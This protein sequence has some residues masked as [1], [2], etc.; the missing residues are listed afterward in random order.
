M[1]PA[2][3]FSGICVV[4]AMALLAWGCGTVYSFGHLPHTDALE[5]SLD[6][7]VSTRAD[8][9]AALGEPR[10]RGGAML[11]GQDG[12]RDLWCYYYEEGLFNDSRRMFL[13][14][15]FKDDVYDGYMWF[16]SL[17]RAPRSSKT[18]KAT[19][20]TV[21]PAEPPEKQAAQE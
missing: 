17:S 11:A 8:V 2:R 20:D 1:A 15:F 7:G 18:Q 13:F 21:T 16:S 3:R 10:S 19:S 12:P 9:L 14:V 5:S 4:F 6:T